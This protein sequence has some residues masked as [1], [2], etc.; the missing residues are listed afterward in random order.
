MESKQMR[1]FLI[2]L[3]WYTI[4]FILQVFFSVPEFLSFSKPVFLVLYACCLAELIWL[5]ENSKQRFVISL[6]VVALSTYAV[7][8]ISVKTGFPF[9][10]YHYSA[11][12]GPLLIGVP[13][14]IA[15]AWVGVLLNSLGISTQKGKFVRALETGIWI[16]VLDLILDPVAVSLNFWTWHEPGN[17][18]YFDIPLSNFVTWFVLGALL[19][20]L[21]PLYQKDKRRQRRITFIF[22]LMLLLFGMLAFRVGLTLIGFFSIC[23]VILVEG[24]YR[25]DY[26]K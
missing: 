16:V 20:Y 11:A 26:R 14:T 12:L 7:E 9:G 1:F 22:Q 6:L 4:G 18:A 5:Q 19:S 24:R 10:S 3:I 21:F 2:F 25:Y 17:F 15:L 8:V 23:F 13:F